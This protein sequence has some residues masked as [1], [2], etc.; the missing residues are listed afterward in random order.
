[1][2]RF[3]TSLLLPLM[4]FVAGPVTAQV[5]TPA[6]RS[7]AALE[8]MLQD[9]LHQPA[10]RFAVDAARTA[11]NAAERAQ[12]SLLAARAALGMGTPAEGLKQIDAARKDLIDTG[13]GSRSTFWEARLLLAGGQAVE[14]SRV[15]ASVDVLPATDPMRVALLRLK[16]RCL[17]EMGREEDALTFFNM[18]EPSPSAG[19]DGAELRLDQAALLLRLGREAEAEPILANLSTTGWST[20]AATEARVWL[21]RMR[22]ARREFD[23]ARRE[24]EPVAT[25]TNTLP[26]VR[27]QAFEVLSD[28]LEGS[29]DLTNAVV[30][31]ERMEAFLLD[32]AD[33]ARARVE[34]A[35]LLIL[36][37]RVEEGAALLR[38]HIAAAGLP[39]GAS[40]SQALVA[41][42]HAA[43]GRHE[44]AV[45][46]WQ[47]YLE[48]FDD[49]QGLATAHYGKGV[50]LARLSRHTEAATSFAKAA[51]VAAA[52]SVRRDA[53]LAQAESLLASGAYAP[54]RE[55]F[56]SLLAGEGIEDDTRSH[57][58]YQAAY[59]QAQ[60]GDAASAEKE[61]EALA[62]ESPG[63]PGGVRALRQVATLREQR[64]AW[65]E[66]IYAYEQ[67]LKSPSSGREVE[68]AR[69][70]LGILHYRQAE[71]DKALADFDGA[72]ATPGESAERALFLKA[73]TLYMMGRNGDGLALAE[74]FLQQHPKSSWADDV[75]YWIG[76]V[77]FNQGDH[78]AAEVFFARL[79]R[80]FPD[81]PTAA[82]AMFWAGRAAAMQK[83]YV[84]AMEY[85]SRFVARHPASPQIPDALFHE[86][87]ALT[88]LGRFPAAILVFEEIIKNH[89]RS[90]LVPAAWGRKGDCCFTLGGADPQRYTEAAR[91]FQFLIE[92]RDTPPEIRW[93]AEYKLAQTLERQGD[94]DSALQHLLAVVY[95][96]ATESGRMD[97]PVAVWFARAALDAGTM[98]ETRNRTPEAAAIYRKLAAAGLA[99]SEE[100]S[101]RIRKLQSAKAPPPRASGS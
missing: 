16:A 84:R 40:Q 47:E 95:G 13:L 93:Q 49:P 97:A 79:I 67:I 76:E 75:L 71:Y 29:G 78:A 70:H 17:L 54:A 26:R 91:A 86:A 22:A 87:D 57:L 55:L 62:L 96:V 11:T 48:A 10:W 46:A 88:S 94:A 41:A 12:A 44:E 35:R 59:C 69:L 7:L 58:R 8:A 43:A 9:G 32:P 68:L 34:R 52:P 66:A 80:E 60:A 37:G 38:A 82:D 45:K 81:E 4:A 24:V 72:A 21:G 2:A 61:L 50:S 83:Q 31:V 100:A 30:S 28:A 99:A 56:L 15:L 42:A 51:D 5:A 65:A 20:L 64:G 27:A 23:A 90:R 74:Q 92:S 1:M 3:R 98:L 89:P 33:L 73:W 53:V 36:S 14:A 85:F 18:A 25:S 63:T 101:A 77:R 39:E 19:E 6:P